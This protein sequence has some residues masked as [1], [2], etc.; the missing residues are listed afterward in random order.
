MVGGPI[1]DITVTFTVTRENLERNPGL[2]RHIGNL[3]TPGARERG[4]LGVWSCSSTTAI[5]IVVV[6][7]DSTDS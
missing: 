7:K 6:E 4:V 3:L 2:A 1:G 5:P